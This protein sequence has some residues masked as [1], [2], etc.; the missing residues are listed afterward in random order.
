[1][2]PTEGPLV[3]VA[4]EINRC[5]SRTCTVP[6]VLRVSGAEGPI[7][8]AFAVAN[9]KGQ[10][11]D[12]H[13]ADCGTGACTVSLVLERGRNTISVGV[14]D[15]FSRSTSYSTL[16]VNANRAVAGVGKTEWF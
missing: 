7:T 3:V 13:H 4:G 15:G 16:R 10:L 9:A 8:V 6:L 5:E 11:S 1:V 14:V 12:V 2:R